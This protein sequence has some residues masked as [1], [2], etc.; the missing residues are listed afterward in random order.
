MLHA[1][2]VGAITGYTDWMERVARDPNAE[3]TP[4]LMMVG[5]ALIALSEHLGMSVHIYGE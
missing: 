1:E 2:V 5:E 4:L 3:A